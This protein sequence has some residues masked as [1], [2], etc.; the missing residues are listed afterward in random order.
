VR[1]FL[2][3]W[4]AG[5]LLFDIGDSFLPPQKNLRVVFGSGKSPSV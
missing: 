5:F 1:I 2:Y 3:L 4:A